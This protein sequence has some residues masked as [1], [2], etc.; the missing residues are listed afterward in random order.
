[1]NAISLLY[2]IGKVQNS[3]A[4]SHLKHTIN[5]TANTTNVFW[6]P[7]FF[8]LFVSDLFTFL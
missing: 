7:F 4:K 8:S 1:M 6:T 3:N 5:Q 2:I